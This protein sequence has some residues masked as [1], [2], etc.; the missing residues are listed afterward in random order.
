MKISELLKPFVALLSLQYS[1]PTLF[2]ES[3]A[4]NNQ[5]KKPQCTFKDPLSELIQ[6]INKKIDHRCVSRD[7]SKTMSQKF[8]NTT[9]QLLKKDLLF[10][11]SFCLFLI[12]KETSILMESHNKS[13]TGKTVQLKNTLRVSFNNNLGYYHYNER[14][15]KHEFWHAYQFMINRLKANSLGLHNKKIDSA[16]YD[17]QAEKKE[18]IEAIDDIK[19]VLKKA[20]KL[21]FSQAHKGKFNPS[22]L[23]HA[24][25]TMSLK[26]KGDYLDL[27]NTTQ[28][29]LTPKQEK[30]LLKLFKG[31][32]N[33]YTPR[34]TQYVVKPHELDYPEIKNKSLKDILFALGPHK[35]FIFT[36]RSIMK[37]NGETVLIGD[38]LSEKP[39]NKKNSLIN[40]LQAWVLETLYNWYGVLG[41]NALNSLDSGTEYD[42]LLKIWQQ[43]SPDTSPTIEGFKTSELDAHLREFPI[44]IYNKYFNKLLQYHQKHKT[45]DYDEY[46]RPVNR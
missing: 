3:A 26:K 41:I 38:F 30:Q 8:I 20:S 39:L 43:I 14:A 37:N 27:N 28:R 16:P 24:I 46:C 42:N 15:V 21:I 36:T 19:D 29:K 4:D 25:K 23:Y 12:P 31:F 40:S 6:K 32:N 44:A 34:D 1:L 17:N 22:L 5:H 7:L 2:A 11:Q 9:V 45:G 18:F 35:A 13:Y 33:T 10:R